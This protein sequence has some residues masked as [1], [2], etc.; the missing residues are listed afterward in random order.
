MT[1]LSEKLGLTPADEFCSMP[2]DVEHVKGETV[3]ARWQ[4][5]GFAGLTAAIEADRR[6][7]VDRVVWFLAH[8][9][10]AQGVDTWPAR[11]ALRDLLEGGGDG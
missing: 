6:A 10:D 8:H 1:T 4:R 7:T 3:G 5:M 2:R 9:Q 11:R